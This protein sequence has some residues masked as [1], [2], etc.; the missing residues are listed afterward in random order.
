MSCATEGIHPR[1]V[2]VLVGRTS[3][4]VP[5]ADSGNNETDKI[6]TPVTPEQRFRAR[7]LRINS[8]EPSADGGIALW[9]SDFTCRHPSSSNNYTGHGNAQLTAATPRPSESIQILASPSR[10]A[11]IRIRRSHHGSLLLRSPAR[12]GHAA[13]MRQIF[14]DASLKQQTPQVDRGALYPQL[15]NVSRRASPPI[16]HNGYAQ[17]Q[18]QRSPC[19]RRPESLRTS[20]S[21]VRPIPR[22]T[23]VS[24][25]RASEQ[26]SESWSDD[27]GYFVPRSRHRSSTLTFAPND[28]IA[29]WLTGVST[30]QR[31]EGGANDQ[32]DHEISPGFCQHF[33]SDFGDDK[34]KGTK[35][36]HARRTVKL[37][38]GDPFFAKEYIHGKLG[39]SLSFS[40]RF[41]S[42]PDPWDMPTHPRPTNVATQPTVTIRPYPYHS[43]TK[44]DRIPSEGGSNS[45]PSA[46]TS[47]SNAA[48]HG[49]TLVAI[50]ETRIGLRLPRP[51]VG[52]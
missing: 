51:D 7:R 42:I 39:S 27:S 34:S 21:S 5:P 1:G 44:H 24:F 18:S 40:S 33:P 10:L 26:S 28:R 17:N 45:V 22:R 25:A 35:Q 50:C 11:N 48:L 43:P 52:R 16:E 23:Q 47:A 2:A 29:E 14:E 37:V 8:A 49:T 13:R 12:A 4:A 31:D 20:A 46:Q 38:D 30:P 6:S 9:P 41:G 19:I 32:E 15:P 36:P 3:S